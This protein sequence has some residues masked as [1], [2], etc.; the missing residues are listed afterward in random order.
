MTPEILQALV[1]QV[2]DIMSF[3]LGGLCALAFV[4]SYS[5]RWES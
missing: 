5:I 3:G 4:L 1:V 2:A